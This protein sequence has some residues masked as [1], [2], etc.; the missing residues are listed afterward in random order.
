MTLNF[1]DKTSLRCLFSKRLRPGV[2]K[3][4]SP[5]ETVKADRDCSHHLLPGSLP[6]VTQAVAQYDAFIDFQLW[7]WQLIHLKEKN[8]LINDIK[9]LFKIS[10]LLFIMINSSRNMFSSTDSGSRS[11]KVK[12]LKTLGCQGKVR[13]LGLINLSSMNVRKKV[14]REQP[15]QDHRDS[16]PCP[17]QNSSS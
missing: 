1:F 4:L 8:E 5:L 6:L 11:R 7:F 13:K 15:Q 2:S 12:V 17:L 14:S 16:W 3:T 10:F 9:I